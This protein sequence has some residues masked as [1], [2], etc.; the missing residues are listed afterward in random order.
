MNETE[1]S[2]EQFDAA[3]AALG[4][5]YRLYAPVRFAGQG[6]LADTDVVRY[7]EV[8]AFAQ[9]EFDRKSD[10][11]PKEVLLPVSQPMLEYTA[12][13]GWVDAAA[14]DGKGIL[15]FLRACDIHAMQR[16]DTIYLHNGP[17][18]P[19]YQRLRGRTKFILI[20]CRQSF[21]NCFCVSMGCNRTDDYAMAVRAAEGAVLVQL[22][23]EQLRYAIPPGARPA[24]FTPH[25]VDAD[26][27]AVELPDEARLA[28]AVPAGLFEHDFWKEYSQ[29]CIACGRCTVVCGDCTCFTTVDAPK[30][31]HAGVIE[32]RRVWA[33][34]HLDRFTDMAG[35]HEF[36]KDYGSR[37]RFRVMHKIYDYPRRFGQPMC[38]GC[39]RCDSI[40]P[41]Y[42]SLSS[43]INKL[44][45]LVKE[46]F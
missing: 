42:I 41:E 27:T 22:R 17:A 37:M 16:L 20:E 35:G 33:S 15:I 30:D 14:D 24:A 11:S 39:G 44:S 6:R 10:F 36:R 31:G 12:A 4:T 13:G 9:I 34:C 1:L 21:E 3:L 28:A 29:R 40:C 26:T 45:A 32:R 46:E 19:W 25:F 8:T 7:A 43:C 5:R 18:D 2:V 23:D 38:T